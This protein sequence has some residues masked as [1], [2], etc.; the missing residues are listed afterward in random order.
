MFMSGWAAVRDGLATRSAVAARMRNAFLV[1][2]MCSVDG[3]QVI[4]AQSSEPL[5]VRVFR[6]FRGFARLVSIFMS[7]GMNE[8]PRQLSTGELVKE[9]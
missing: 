9:F 6:V 4:Q 5:K 1:F 3:V 7:K 2:I 8:K